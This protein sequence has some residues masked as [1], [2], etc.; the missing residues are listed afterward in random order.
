MTRFGILLILMTAIL[1][2]HALAAQNAVTVADNGNSFTLA[3]GRVTAKI[4]K[5]SGDLLS[6]QYQNL[7][8]LDTV[9]QPQAGYWSHNAAHGKPAVARVT[10][11]P[12]SNHGERG[13]VAVKGIY[14]GGG[15]AA[16]VEIRY[17]LGRGDT[18]LYTYSIFTHATNYP[19]TSIGEAR[20]C[21]K[22]NDRWFDWMTVDS[23][24][25]LEMITAYDWN[26]G[27]ELNFKEV[28][29][30]NTG[31]YR[32]QAEHKYDYAA[33]QFDVRTWGWCSTQ[34]HVGIWF[35]NPSV[36]Y[37]SGGPTKVELSAHR[38]ATFDTRAL[39]APAPPC[40]L[41]YWRSSH[42][43]GS[44][45]SIAATDAWSKVIGPF[46]IYCNAATNRDAL[47][48]DALA[49]Q[50]VEESA[51]PFDWVQGVDYPH[52]NQR[53]TVSGQIHLTDPTAPGLKMTNLLVGLS[54]PDYL[55]PRQRYAW[56]APSLVTWQLDAQHYQFWARAD[57]DGH[58]E[59][60]NVRPGTYTLHAIADGV[61]GEFT[62]PRVTVEAGKPLELGRRDWR[63]VRHGRQL[64][65]IGIPNR[66]AAEFYKGDDYFH[67]GWYIRY[68]KLFPRDVH[69]VIDQ[70]DYR[71]DWFFEQVPHDENPADTTSNRRG[72]QTTWTV[73]FR[74]PARPHGK[75]TL[76]LSIC[77]VGARSLSVKMNDQ[78]IGTLIDLIYNATINRDGIGGT[79]YEHDLTFDASRMRA[80]ENTLA[81][82]IPAGSLTSGIMYDYLRLELDDS[83]PPT[84]SDSS[85]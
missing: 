73:S 61:L 56:R 62:L 19:A 7:E 4:S 58:F 21:A 67:W 11:E 28:R 15:L 84:T 77:G 69:Y 50:T 59:I 54:A 14:D 20:F 80:G 29:R 49:R 6:L 83:T 10:I 70:S 66:T 65:D 33:N 45:C 85:K 60:P 72:R 74:L 53:A 35:I 23:N 16:D 37:L 75:A 34:R 44:V 22:L 2:P 38:D 52:R 71:R 76:R 36:E 42:Y 9:D 51:W 1:F 79:C 25:N 47:W 43:G 17:A 8:M 46:L 24:R 12:Q 57:A 40:L 32:G 27:T 68:A 64:W 3:N 41:N 13:E 48:R 18:G 30:M 55:P 81:L 63:P 31:L 39:H 82:T 78:P 26:H 5:Q